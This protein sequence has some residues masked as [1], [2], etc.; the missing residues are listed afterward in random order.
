[1][2]ALAHAA[3][4]YFFLLYESVCPAALRGMIPGMGLHLRCGLAV[5]RALPWGQEPSA[6][7]RGSSRAPF[8]LQNA[9]CLTDPLCHVFPV[10]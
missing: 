3:V 7:K 9:V 5:P 4:S 2:Y 10:P 1:M 8:A 6:G